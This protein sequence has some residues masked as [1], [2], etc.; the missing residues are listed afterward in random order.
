MSP[1]TPCLRWMGCIALCFA[2]L[3]ALSADPGLRALFVGIGTYQNADNA[4]LRELKGPGNDVRA[5]KAVVSDRFGLTGPNTTVLLNEQA[6]RAALLAAIKK[7]LVE[8]AK[9]GEVALF[10]FSGHGSRVFDASSDEPSKFDSTILP[11]DARAQQGQA[12]DIID[13]EL[14]AI[15]SASIAKGVKPFVILDSCNSG[16][17]IR[18]RA[19][20]R[21]A[22]PIKRAAA[23]AP[24][25]SAPRSMREIATGHGTLLAAAQDT[26]EA[27]EME[28]DGIVH[29]EFTRALVAILRSAEKD[30]TYLDVLTRVRVSLA[31]LGVPHRPQGEGDLQQRFLGTGPL[32]SPPILAERVDAGSVRLEIGA[33]SAITKGS[34]YDFYG[35]AAAAVGGKAP[36]TSG[37]VEDVQPDSAT[38]K[39]TSSP[40]ALPST[41]FALERSHAYGDLKLQVAIM[42]GTELQRAQLEAALANLDYVKTVK[43]NAATHWLQV[44]D[45]EAQLSLVDGSPLG[46]PAKLGAE[47][48]DSLAVQLARLAHVQALLSLKNPKRPKS[49]ITVS[50]VLAKRE[51]DTNL[52]SPVMRDGEARIPL[53][54]TYK[55]SLFNT[56]AKPRHVYLLN[57]AQ[58]LCVQLLSPPP[59]GKDEPLV[60]L[61]HTRLLK[62]G[63]GRG[64]ETFIVIATDTPI[65]VDA[66]PRRCLEP[67]TL[68]TA[69]AKRYRDPLSQLLGNARS[70]K[71]GEQRSLPLD[72]WSTGFL[73]MVVE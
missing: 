70:T 31:A 2:C 1:R 22:P 68:R 47:V 73:T 32:G 12:L 64:R 6:T 14:G 10:Y 9:P 65:S 49:P 4:G 33:A 67:A 28:R 13:D 23:I 27:L 7:V 60:G 25:A 20:A 24:A 43:P 15:V 38:V 58:N 50:I 42:G 71:R 57:L 56:E 72:G 55:V 37:L 30:V 16:T 3:P 29:G 51:S 8:D 53:S 41:L 52:T 44:K 66:L 61:A 36:L 62:A 63:T 26:E 59:R 69:V 21:Y 11:Y 46:Y 18:F 35:T 40:A 54:Q 17:G 45:G 48:D 39:L 5:V 34:L 19:Q